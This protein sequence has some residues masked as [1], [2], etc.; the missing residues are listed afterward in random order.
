M[1]LLLFALFYGSRAQGCVPPRPEAPA[2]QAPDSFCG[3]ASPESTSG[4][5]FSA[6]RT[7]KGPFALS[8]SIKASSNSGGVG[9]AAQ[10]FPLG[11]PFVSTMAPLAE[12][13]FSSTWSKEWER[14][15][16]SRPSFQLGR[17]LQ[18][19]L[20]ADRCFAH[21]LPPLCTHKKRE[22]V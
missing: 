10:T 15:S 2:Q 9:P 20:A 19:P 18:R 16:E 14:T 11:L 1:W 4:T 17:V 13:L 7:R 5:C 21:A 6:W 22:S 8:C 12:N 3:S